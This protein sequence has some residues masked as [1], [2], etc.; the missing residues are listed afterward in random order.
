HQVRAAVIGERSRDLW[1]NVTLLLAAVIVCRGLFGFLPI[2][3]SQMFWSFER[4][5]PEIEAP[6]VQGKALAVKAVTLSQGAF[7][8]GI[9][10]VD[11]GGD[12]EK[13]LK[14]MS[15]G[16]VSEEGSFQGTEFQLP[17]TDADLRKAAL[18]LTIE[19]GMLRLRE[20]GE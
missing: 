20:K 15:A 14:E 3:D 12:V 8:A 1:M 18:F 10:F 2:D 19:D 11:R 9:D 6:S 5:L 17:L 7:W 13:T 16:A 4:F